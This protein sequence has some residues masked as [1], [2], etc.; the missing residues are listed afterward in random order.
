MHVALT[1][2]LATCLQ[3]AHVKAWVGSVQVTYDRTVHAP[4]ALEH[5][6]GNSATTTHYTPSF[7]Q[8]IAFNGYD[9]T[10]EGKPSG[11][12]HIV[13]DLTENDQS[14]P[15]RLEG[16]GPVLADPPLGKFGPEQFWINSKK[17][18]YA[19]YSSAAVNAMH[20][21]DGTMVDG[22]DMH[23]ENIPLPRF[24]ALTGSRH[25]HIPNPTNYRGGDQFHIPCLLVE[26]CSRDAGPGNATISWTF[27]AGPG[28]AP[29]AVPS[30]KANPRP[31]CPNADA[32]SGSRVDRLRIDFEKAL[33]AN[34]RAV[35]LGDIAGT[36]GAL[37][38]ITVRLDGFGRALPSQQCIDEGTANGSVPSGS[39]FGAQKLLL[40]SVQQAG[41]QT[42]VTVRIV[43]VATGAIQSSGLADA[44]GTSDAAIQQAATSAIQ[45]VAAF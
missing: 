35:P 37:S 38:K 15:V 27:T 23:V 19:F 44:G 45:K 29:H 18:V 5:S 6:Y 16:S 4:W 14:R 11:T 1:F 7:I 36:L 41:N 13:D 28:V 33:A 10:W 20:S 40:A 30:P 43:D 42:R 8:V 32:S 12:A 17:C 2:L 34:G 25:F 31:K 26:W 9:E 39:Q 3:F 22:V 24:G 21:R